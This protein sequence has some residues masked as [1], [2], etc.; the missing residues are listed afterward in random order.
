MG[1]GGQALSA[2]EVAGEV[3]PEAGEVEG[4]VF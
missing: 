2:G 1:G 3:F 4:D